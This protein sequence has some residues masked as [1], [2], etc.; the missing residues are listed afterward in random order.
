M[1]AQGQNGGLCGRRAGGE[2]FLEV[3]VVVV[4]SRIRL[5]HF[6]FKNSE[7]LPGGPWPPTWLYHSKL[8]SF[9]TR[10]TQCF[11]PPCVLLD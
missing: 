6:R 2:E 3:P 11:A 9:A 1:I 5:V 10:Q 8:A 7:S 4:S